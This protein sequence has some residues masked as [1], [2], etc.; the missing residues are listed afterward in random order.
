MSRYPRKKRGCLGCVA[1]L[2]KLLL[3]GVVV[4]ALVMLWIG[5]QFGRDI[6][7]GDVPQP[8]VGDLSQTAGLDGAWTNI[9]LLGR[10]SRDTADS[11]LTDTMIV[12]SVNSGSG[13]IKMTSLMRDTMVPIAGRGTH[14]L[15]AAHAYGGPNLAMKTVNQAFGLNISHYASVDFI[16][17]PQIIDSIGGI[18][19]DV[20]EAELPHINSNINMQKKIWKDQ[21]IDTSPLETF[22]KNTHLTGLQALAFSRIRKLDSDY[23]RASRQRAVLDAMLKKV[24]STTNPLTLG[25]T[26]MSLIKYVDT[27]VGMID[28]TRYAAAALATSKIEEYR[29]PVDGTFDSG[30]E[31]GIWSI[32]ADLDKNTQLLREFIYKK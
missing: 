5:G 1:S 19:L 32:R 6:G 20:S 3:A 9:L 27:N 17:F 7:P 16:S 31:D 10:D 12:L 15:N 29:V 4:W 8:D 14:K 23:Q 24:R 18:E 26:V 25:A 13:R 28:M 30:N 22:G 11:G 21:G 2:I